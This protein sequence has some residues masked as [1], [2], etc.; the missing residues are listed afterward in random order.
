MTLQRRVMLF[1]LVSAP[2]VWAAGLLFGLNRAH[3]EINELFDTQQVQMARLV[4]AALPASPSGLPDAPLP[5]PAGRG[6]GEADVEDLS[7][8]VWDGQGRLR[9]ADREGVQLPFRAE[10]DG[11]VD[12][13]LAGADWRVYYQR[14]GPGGWL[15]AVG[16]PHEERDE[17]VQALLLGQL[18][19]WVLTLPLLLLAMAAAL[20]QALKPLRRLTDDLGRR[21]AADLQPLSEDGLTADLRPLVQ[22]T[23]RL[24]LRLREQIE[25]ERRF[26]ADAAHE[27]RTPLAALQAQWD[28]AQAAGSAP[29][30]AKIGEGLERLSRLVAQMLD[31]ARLEQ[32]DL[33]A[34]QLP[35]DWMALVEQLFSELLPLAEARGVELEC[36]WP[37]TGRKPLLER[38]DAPLLALMLRNLLHNALRHA[39]PRSCV[40]LRLQ[41][42]TIEVW[43]QGPGV[44]APHLPRLG[45]RFF[46]LPGQADAGSG[47]G[48]SIARRIAALHGLVLEWQTLTPA[49][50]GSG[51]FVAR[52][53]SA[54][55]DR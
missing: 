54:V 19:P 9:L 23:N 17:L 6:R 7:I 37:P 14:A 10:G 25:H 48:L 2:L 15:V 47:L 38:G 32:H 24:L 53:R 45:D 49:D 39:P 1:L 26:T 11:F 44:P 36:R 20:R 42:E 22:A 16:Q 41:A 13:P 52:L 27:L 35:I 28:A 33:Q 21:Q 5:P 31:L 50:G 46:R 4:Q 34:R 51:G 3:H 29:G 18:A 40:S 30:P 8:A 55:N 43:D 12:L